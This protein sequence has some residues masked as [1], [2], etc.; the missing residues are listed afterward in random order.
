MCPSFYHHLLVSFIYC[1][2]VCLLIYLVAVHMAQ[3]PCED[4]LEK[5]ILS[6]HRVGPG[7]RTRVSGLEGKCIYTVNHLTILLCLK[8]DKTTP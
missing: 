2:L 7:D 5:L 8:T 6:Y 4:N 3:D 1:L